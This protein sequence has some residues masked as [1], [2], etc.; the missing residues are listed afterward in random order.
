MKAKKICCLVAL[1]LLLTAC[2]GGPDLPMEATVDGYTI[3][4][5]QTT[6]QDMIDQGYEVHPTGVPDTMKQGDK[7]IP[8]YYS[9]DR[10]AGD[11]VFVT[12]CVPWGGSANVREEQKLSLTEGVIKSVTLRLSATEKVEVTYNGMDL[13]ELTF[14]HAIKEWGAEKDDRTTKTAYKLTAKR[15]FLRLEAENTFSEEFNA[16]TVQL[17]Q[18]EFEKMQGK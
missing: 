3:V 6:M 12:A 9:L 4:L 16:L 15:G 17:S 13:S 1:L 10:G 14:D 18:K 8:F 11:Q 5:G 7:Y 2:G